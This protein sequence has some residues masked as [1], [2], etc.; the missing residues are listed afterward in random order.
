MADKF[1][2]KAIISAV[3]K[4]TPTLKNVQ[5][6]VKLTSKT[7]SDISSAGRGLLGGLGIPA[8]LAFG[9]VIYGAQRA[10]NAALAFAGSIKDAA[11]R[12]GMSAAAY[13]ELSVMLSNV[14]GA[15]EDAAASAEKFNKGVADAAAGAD[16]NFLALMRKMG[17]PL[18]N[19]RGELVRL[20][21][22]LPDIAESFARTTDPALRTRMVM[23][24]FGKSGG[25]LLPIL[26]LGREGVQDW[27]AEI[28]RLGMTVD[29]EAI[30]RL[31]DMGDSIGDV[32]QAIKAQWTRVVADLAPALMPAIKGMGEW[33]AANK[34]MLRSEIT[35]AI[36]ELVSTLKSY[37]WRGLVADLRGAGT[38]VAD[39]VRSMGGLKNVLL[40]LGAIFLAGPVASI[41]GI[42]GALWRFGAGLLAI[43]GGWG[44]VGTAIMAVGKVFAVIGRL[45]LLNPVGLAVTAIAT[46]AYLV[47]SN[48]D[49]IKGWFVDFFNWLPEKIR[50]IGQWFKG[51]APDWAVRMFGGTP[52]PSP[53]AAP[54]ARPGALLGGQQRLNGE[55]TVRFENAPPGMRVSEGKTNLPGLALNPDV[56]HRSLG[57]G[58]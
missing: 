32:A 33:I 14:G 6:S 4:I 29:D 25:K 16:K 24:L 27:A 44:A 8:G 36:T 49:R 41:L 42:V 28:R 12:T 55:M 47:Y 39:V 15:E 56:G 30:D 58:L 18:R 43:A 57:L 35:G 5:R 37:D 17:I 13:Q 34:D 51:M 23:E 9:S 10:T 20:E 11:D 38:A 45:F 26:K 52:A 48:W 22:V 3:D 46:A 21:E 1:N 54:A 50:S 31:D 19:A 7:I 40:G 53:A 2:L